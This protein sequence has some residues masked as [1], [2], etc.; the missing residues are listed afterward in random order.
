MHNYSAGLLLATIL[1]GEFSYG[2]A[3]LYR[4]FQWFSS[5]KVLLKIK[6]AKGWLR[7]F[8]QISIFKRVDTI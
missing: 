1:Y 4:F 2:V 8:F 6:F 7:Y 5:Q 3:I